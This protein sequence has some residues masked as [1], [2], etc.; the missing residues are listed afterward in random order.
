MFSTREGKKCGRGK[1]PGKPG[2]PG[3]DRDEDTEEE[4][5]EGFDEDFMKQMDALKRACQM[6][7][8]V[9]LLF[10]SFPS[11]TCSFSF[12]SVELLEFVNWILLYYSLLAAGA[13]SFEYWGS[14]FVWSIAQIFGT[15]LGF[16]ANL[17]L[18]SL[19]DS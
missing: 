10:F 19:G 13:C 11:S 1:A 12:L 3:T 17:C 6:H 9:T 4:E 8:S 7:V 15:V 14:D 5:E 2:F 18:T 16:G